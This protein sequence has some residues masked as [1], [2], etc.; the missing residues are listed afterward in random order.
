M[1]NQVTI[2][3][4]RY[5][6]L[7]QYEEAYKKRHGDNPFQSCNTDKFFE[8]PYINICKPFCWQ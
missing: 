5:K 4:E 8:Q 3:E 6:Q 1:A 7:L 2:S